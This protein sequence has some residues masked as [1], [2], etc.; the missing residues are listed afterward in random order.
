MTPAAKTDY[1]DLKRVFSLTKTEFAL[2]TGTHRTTV[3]RWDPEP[4]WVR[5]LLAAWRTH[6]DLLAQARAERALAE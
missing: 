4:P 6:P 2:L 3:H 1:A 5:H